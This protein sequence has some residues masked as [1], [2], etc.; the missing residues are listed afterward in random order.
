VEVGTPQTKASALA[1]LRE[2]WLSLAQA[3]PDD[4][5]VA[6]GVDEDEYPTEALAPS[7]A[8]QCETT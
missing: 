2:L 3:S 7:Q 4:P 1:Q 8:S 6:Y 5:F